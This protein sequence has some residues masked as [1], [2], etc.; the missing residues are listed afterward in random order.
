[1]TVVPADGSARMRVDRLRRE[2]AARDAQAIVCA[3]AG[4]VNTGAFDDLDAIADVA[5]EA[6]AWLH[7][8]GA[9]GLW[10]AASPAL[11]HLVNGAGRADSWAFVRPDLRSR[12]GVHPRI[13]DRN[14][15]CNRGGKFL[16]HQCNER[17]SPTAVPLLSMIPE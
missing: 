6:G 14:L 16:A 3:Q 11:R 10:A 17:A 1:M 4:E 9:F 15:Q 2:L 7:I 8:D 12:L 13:G 5:A